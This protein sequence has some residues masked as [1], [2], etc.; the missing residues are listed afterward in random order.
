MQPP[1]WWGVVSS[2]DHNVYHTI[3][4]GAGQAGLAAAYYLQRAGHRAVLLEQHDRVG[5]QWRQRWAGLRLF[6]PQRY[7]GLPGWPP[8]GDAWYTPSRLEVADY[9]EGYAAR[10]AFEVRTRCTCVR[11]RKDGAVWTVETSC[12]TLTARH[13]VVASGAYRT[14]WVP[15]AIADSFPE[16]I[17]QY[18]SSDIRDVADVAG[19]DTDALVVGAG[20][21]GQQL[22]RLLLQAGSN[23]TLAGPAVGNLPRRLLGRDIYWWLYASGMMTVRTDRWPGKLLAGAGGGDVTVAEPPLPAAV[24][25]VPTEIARYADGHLRCKCERTAPR[26]IPFPGPSKRGVVVWCTGYRNAYPFLPAALLDAGGQPRRAGVR[27]SVDPTVSYLG[28]PNLRRP[29]SSLLG[30]VGRDAAELVV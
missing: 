6:S 1:A 12:G 18:H 9:L 19:P 8:A 25:R 17:A 7:N 30:G 10:F 27:S 16:D 4:I 28:L 5:D 22:S 13:L 20:A 11:A 26:P 2:V 23:V 21:S 14:P 15:R 3:I 29:N 24:Q